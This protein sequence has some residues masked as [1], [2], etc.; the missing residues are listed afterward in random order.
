MSPST[1]GSDSSLNSFFMYKTAPG[2]ESCQSLSQK[3]LN[4]TIFPVC[5]Q[6]NKGTEIVRH[7]ITDK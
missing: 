7:H 2:D 3:I 4:K 1:V 5:S 6:Q